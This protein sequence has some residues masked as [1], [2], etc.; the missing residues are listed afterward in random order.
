[1]KNGGRILVESKKQRDLKKDIKAWW[2]GEM[3][4][5]GWIGVVLCCRSLLD[6]V[7]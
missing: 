2:V 6:R 1:M 3:V 5:T 4:L 7:F